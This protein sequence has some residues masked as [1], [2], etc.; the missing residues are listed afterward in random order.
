[1]F[2]NMFFNKKKV[3]K[4]RDIK[5]IKDAKNKKSK[6]VAY[7]EFYDKESVENAISLTGSI[8]RGNEIKI[9]PSQAEKNRM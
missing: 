8:L 1:M 9:Q 4:I 3:G 7:V 2:F 5:L 6:G